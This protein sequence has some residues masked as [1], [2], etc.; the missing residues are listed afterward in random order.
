MKKFSLLF[1]FLSLSLAMF[2]QRKITG[3]IVDGSNND[4]LVGA[5]VLVKD[6]KRGVLT[7]VDGTF[8]IQAETGETLVASFV[9]YLPKEIVIGS[10]NAV[11]FN[12]E[13]DTRALQEV[14]V[15][16][17]GGALNKR[18]ITGAISK[19]KGED[20]ENLPVA[21]FDK[22]IQGR[23]AG[24]QVT[25]ANGIPGGATQVRIRG[26][27]SISGGNDPLYIVDGV[28]LNS[29]TR[30]SFTSSN[31]LNFL[32]PNDIESIEILK[33]ASAA[34]IY[35]SQAANGVILVTTKKKN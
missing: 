12:L 6:T 10:S 27:G 2:G 21:S 31:P 5:T 14:V 30:S 18:E 9:G 8:T 23:A 11:D 7:D 26:I 32:N 34:S 1:I 35:G 24:V 3:K 29:T 22:A 20:I 19:V 4:A 25:S 13:T 33:D 16:G 28:Q 17:Y 15:T